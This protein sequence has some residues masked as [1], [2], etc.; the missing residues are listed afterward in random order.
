MK[1][2]SSASCKL[3]LFQHCSR[4]NKMY[5]GNSPPLRDIINQRCSVQR[6]IIADG[7]HF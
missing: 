6:D 2:E 3:L 4:Q 1:K 7:P 5:T